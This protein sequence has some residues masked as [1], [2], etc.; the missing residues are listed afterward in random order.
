MKSKYY[1]NES[2]AWLWMSETIAVLCVYFVHYDI[3]T[4]L[5][6]DLIGMQYISIRI[7]FRVDCGQTKWNIQY[8]IVSNIFIASLLLSFNFE[9]CLSRIF[10]SLFVRWM[11]LFL[12]KYHH[13]H[14]HGCCIAGLFRSCWA[15]KASTFVV[16]SNIYIYEHHVQASVRQGNIFQNYESKQK[17]PDP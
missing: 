2:N 1:E 10:D 3:D 5:I 8:F 15:M 17:R 4:R 14:R 13:K 9:F 6:S 16:L 12:W 7:W 11:F